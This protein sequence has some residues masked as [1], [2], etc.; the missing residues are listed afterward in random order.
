MPTAAASAVPANGQYTASRA[1]APMPSSV[2]RSG[3]TGCPGTVVAVG[4]GVGLAGAVPL[5][6][7]VEPLFVSGGK[8]SAFI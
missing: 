6:A 4:V 1:P 7:G 8:S 3:Y 2:P 5:G